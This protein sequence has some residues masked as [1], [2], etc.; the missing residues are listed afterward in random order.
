MSLINFMPFFGK[1]ELDFPTPDSNMNV[2]LVFGDNMRGKTSL[3]NAMRWCFYQ[4][5]LDRN[6]KAY[7]WN[8]M[9]NKV[10]SRKGDWT[11]SV[12]LKFETDEGE[13]EL[14]RGI[15]KRSSVITPLKD[16][17]FK[18][19][20][21]LKTNGKPV[22]GSEIE[23]FIQRLVPEET[24]R[25]FLFDGEL[26]QEY[27][28]LLQEG[29][30]QGEAIK[31]SI[32]KVLGVPALTNGRNELQLILK[33]ANRI[34]RAEQGKRTGHERQLE[35]MSELETLTTAIEGDIEELRDKLASCSRE[36]KEIETDIVE[37]DRLFEKKVELDTLTNRIKEHKTTIV[38]GE[39]ERLALRSGLWRELLVS[40][41]QEKLTSL[42]EEQE[43]LR[44][45]KDLNTGKSYMLSH[46]EG[47]LEKDICPTCDQE[48]SEGHK[49]KIS[50]KLDDV[51]TSLSEQDVDGATNRILELSRM[52]GNLNDFSGSNLAQRLRF[53][54][55]T[56]DKSNIKIIEHETKKINLEIELESTDSEAIK[57]KRG[58][59]KILLQEE[60]RLERDIE[61]QSENLEKYYSEYNTL[62]ELMNITYSDKTSF[63]NQKI[64]ITT[65]LMNVFRDSIAVLRDD[66]KLRVEEYASEAFKQLT[67][68]QKYKG[69]QIN[70]NYGLNI[71]DHRDEILSIRS[72]GAEQIV[73]LSLII[74]LSKINMAN[75]PVV[76]DTPFGRLDRKHRSSVLKY[77]PESANQLILLVHD[78]EVNKDVDLDPIKVRVGLALEIV[79]VEPDHSKIV[80]ISL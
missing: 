33:D 17:D 69:L 65:H 21:L 1:A 35:K 42:H 13:H 9:V 24:S 59:Y 7:P 23:S 67:T 6:M 29:S 45:R 11:L 10:A 30:R 28:D 31:G 66:L 55:N 37:V 2:L 36:R 8:S 72:A 39:A 25:F 52:I 80:R 73:A 49:S 64:N 62:S 4:V 41:V 44:Q 22:A 43:A 18:T 27:E 78:G 76:M 46:L 5:A 32:E 50:K 77:F 16:S 26:L 79:E 15:E 51:R 74:G 34:L 12:N 63:L 68:Q 14:I 58:R 70:D 40:K 38:D 61:T 47:I 54:E 19:S 71:I 57:R 75:G 53:I 3:L 20:L 60:G 56:I 48:V